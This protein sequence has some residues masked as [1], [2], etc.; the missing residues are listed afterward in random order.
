MAK[1]GKQ[2]IVCV[3]A[4]WWCAGLDMV[5]RRYL[6]TSKLWLF[7][8]SGHSKTEALRTAVWIAFFKVE[9]VWFTF[10]TSDTL[11]V[12]L[13][14]TLGRLLVT[15]LLGDAGNFTVTLTTAGKPGVANFAL[16]AAPSSDMFLTAVTQSVNLSIDL[17]RGIW[18][19]CKLPRLGSGQIPDC[20]LFWTQPRE[21]V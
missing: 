17:A 1:S 18:S 21:Q 7:T 11:D 15:D 19:A 2:D 10:R 20:K 16:V 6:I 12:T 9:R 14:E 3:W 13:T 5:D 4:N 8:A